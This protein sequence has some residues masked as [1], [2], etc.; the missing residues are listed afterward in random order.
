M[1][2]FGFW[3]W[4]DDTE[5]V[6]NKKRCEKMFNLVR[7]PCFVNTRC[8]SMCLKGCGWSVWKRKLRSTLYIWKSLNPNS[9]KGVNIRDAVPES[10]VRMRSPVQIWLAAPEFS[11]NADRFEDLNAT[12]TSVAGEGLTEPLHDVAN[13]PSNFW[14]FLKTLAHERYML[15]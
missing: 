5:M 12:R 3:M 7:R 13:L 4:R 1:I 10:L 14:R 15:L 11:S 6:W 2:Y 9:F 8:D